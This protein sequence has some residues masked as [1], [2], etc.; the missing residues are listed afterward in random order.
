MKTRDHLDD[1]YLRMVIDGIREAAQECTPQADGDL[2]EC[3][4]ELGNEFDDVV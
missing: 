2:R 4:G 3:R 1:V